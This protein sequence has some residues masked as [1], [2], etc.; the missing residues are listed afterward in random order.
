MTTLRNCK[1]E[2]KINPPDGMLRRGEK[3]TLTVSGTRDVIL[4]IEIDPNVKKQTLVECVMFIAKGDGSLL[5]LTLA[6]VGRERR[7]LDKV[8]EQETA[9]LNQMVEEKDRLTAWLDS[10]RMKPLAE[11]GPAK[12][13][14]RALT[15]QIPSQTSVVQS[16]Q[17]DLDVADRVQLL[18]EHLHDDCAIEIE[19]VETSSINS[20]D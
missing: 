11:V 10:P 20:G 13:Q 8:A 18:T 5:P 7:R 1:T 15:R 3:V 19:V 6:N 16:L 4:E 17:A 9:A 14:V 12:S 2:C